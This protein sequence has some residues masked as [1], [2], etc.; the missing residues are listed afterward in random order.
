[1]SPIHHRICDKDRVGMKIL[2][3]PSCSI[4][5][6]LIPIFTTFPVRPNIVISSPGKKVLS[7][8]AEDRNNGEET[9]EIDDYLS[10]SDKPRFNLLGEVRLLEYSPEDP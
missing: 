1:M 9:R 10:Y 6:V 2:C 4:T 3:P 5:V 7:V 8:D